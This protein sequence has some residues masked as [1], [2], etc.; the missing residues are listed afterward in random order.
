MQTQKLCLECW[1]KSLCFFLNGCDQG[2][3]EPWGE[4][5]WD[6]LEAE[7]RDGNIL[8][9]T[10]A[11]L[12][13]WFFLHWK[14]LGAEYA[15]SLQEK[16]PADGS[17]SACSS[18]A[19]QLLDPFSLFKDNRRHL[20]GQSGQ[21]CYCSQALRKP[22]YQYP[23]KERPRAPRQIPALSRGREPRRLHSLLHF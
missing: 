19:G 18:K 20:G 5:I 9:C 15:G 8:A 3:M 4:A 22:G 17:N 21:V 23:G 16:W 7:L 2:S 6:L 10:H 11:C 13:P 14:V 1:N 12:R